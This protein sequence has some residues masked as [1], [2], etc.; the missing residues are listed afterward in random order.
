MR[1][2][3]RNN[4]SRQ[5][6]LSNVMYSDGDACEFSSPHLSTGKRNTDLVRSNSIDFYSDS[7]Y[8][9]ND[10][11]PYP[12]KNPS[13]NSRRNNYSP[14]RY[15]NF[16]YQRS[17]SRK[18]MKDIKFS[19][20][21]DS[22]YENNNYDRYKNKK[23]ESYSPMS[24]DNFD[25]NIKVKPYGIDEKNEAPS[26]EIEMSKKNKKPNYKALNSQQKYNTR[27]M[28]EGKFHTL[29]SSYPNRNIEIPSKELSL[30]E[31]H[32]KYEELVKQ[33][34]V[35]IN[36]D[37]WKIYVMIGFAMIEMYGRFYLGMNDLLE[38]FTLHHLKNVDRFDP[39]LVQL[40]IKYY[41]SE[42]SQWPTELVIIGS[43][44][45]QGI[46]F[47]G[48][49]FI[50]SKLG[51]KDLSEMFHNLASNHFNKINTAAPV[52][53]SE[54]GLPEPPKNNGGGIESILSSV[55]GGGGNGIDLQKIMGSVLSG[56]NGGGNAQ[57]D[58][59][60]KERKVDF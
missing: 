57:P 19:K 52:T 60:K 58:Q 24:D 2:S 23:N 29:K 5:T 34:V 13:I 43:I 7:G 51:K 27:I 21:Q 12:P 59:K 50:C 9:D 3:P 35:D 41:S 15:S 16:S 28:F 32:D 45:F 10:R 31:I 25:D 48:I 38:G 56:L 37:N 33:I 17:S 8:E 46:V 54:T 40:G 49:N 42:E 14:Q 36:K 4:S 22:R 30:D 47:A 44:I 26:V 55:M 53:D 39:L 18:K 6:V 11:Y 1:A 20:T